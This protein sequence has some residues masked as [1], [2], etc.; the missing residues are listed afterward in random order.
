MVQTRL[1]GQERP[2]I[3]ASRKLQGE[4]LLVTAYAPTR[5]RLE[6]DSRN[7]WRD[8][9]HIGLKQLWEYIA[10][11]LYMPRFKNRDVLVKSVQAGVGQM[12]WDT[13]A[14]AES[15]DESRERYRGLVMGRTGVAVVL[16]GQSVLVKPDAAS[17]QL[18]VDEQQRQPQPQPTGHTSTYIQGRT[19]A[20]ADGARPNESNGA[21][22]A[23]PPKLRRFHGTVDLNPMRV[24]R[25][26]GN[27]AQEIIQH[28]T[29]LAGANATI[30]LEIEVE[31]PDG[32]P[33]QVVRT[34]SENCRTLKF[35]SQGFEER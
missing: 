15:W 29:A 27:I 22:V 23:A 3:K 34:V 18:D 33:E 2:A 28:L 19:D 31:M 9:D 7:L 30:T 35:T 25:D 14:Y 11:Y 26:A 21:Y 5:L 16:D 17:K 8:Q 12:G 32:A 6:L 4:E 10:N 1:Q 24:G 13:F 20:G